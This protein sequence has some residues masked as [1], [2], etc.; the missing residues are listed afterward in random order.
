[1]LNQEKETKKVKAL[2]FAILFS[3]I[4][5]FKLIYEVAESKKMLRISVENLKELSGFAERCL[6]PNK[7]LKGRPKWI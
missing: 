7:V 2:L 6:Q 3:M 4:F 1:M 5:N